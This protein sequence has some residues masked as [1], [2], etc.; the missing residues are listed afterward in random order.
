MIENIVYNTYIPQQ[1]RPGLTFREALVNYIEA[2]IHEL[3][4][5]E[6]AWIWQTQNMPLLMIQGK[7]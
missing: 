1:I 4:S 3:K 6:N 5:G 2:G 7:G